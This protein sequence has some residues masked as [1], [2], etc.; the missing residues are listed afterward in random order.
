[1]GIAGGFKSLSMVCSVWWHGMH[2]S[3]GGRDGLLSA[4]SGFSYESG[5]LG[6]VD[7]SRS[8][9]AQRSFMIITA[10][11]SRKTICKS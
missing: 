11:A 10:R 3:A 4:K 8:L 7:S 2:Y 9:S 6:T 1:M 5:K